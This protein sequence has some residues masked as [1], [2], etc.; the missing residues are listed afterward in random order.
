MILIAVIW[1]AVAGA[2]FMYVPVLPVLGAAL[3]LFGFVL[4]FVVGVQVGNI[5]GT[6]SQDTIRSEI[7]SASGTNCGQAEVSPNASR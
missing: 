4:M 3:V 6:P 7:L 1:I 2:F 5:A